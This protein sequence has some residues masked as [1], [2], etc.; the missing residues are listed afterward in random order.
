MSSPADADFSGRPTI[1]VAGPALLCAGLTLVLLVVL[2]QSGMVEAMDRELVRVFAG[3][4]GETPVQHLPVAMTWSAAALVAL[5]LPLALFSCPH[6]W[7]RCLLWLSSVVV[8]AAWAPVL[9]L[10]AHHPGVS[11]PVLAALLSG[12][13]VLI[14]L[15]WLHRGRRDPISP[16]H[17]ES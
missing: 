13:L 5:L 10:A 11:L 2:R 7:Q 4:L 14:Q 17:E 15:A 6:A 1:P 3:H 12:L 8:L 9:A 16:D